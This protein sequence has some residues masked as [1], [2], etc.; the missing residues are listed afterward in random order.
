MLSLMY[1]RRGGA[2]CGGFL[3]KAASCFFLLSIG[4]VKGMHQ[5][6]TVSRVG[7]MT[8][9][10]IIRLFILLSQRL[11]SQQANPALHPHG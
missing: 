4:M 2:G 5:T 6:C 3:M 9:R 10:R 8:N 11:N 7:Q 1:P